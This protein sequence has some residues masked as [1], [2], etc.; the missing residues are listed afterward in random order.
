MSEVL[1]SSRTIKREAPELIIDWED[2]RDREP[3]GPGADE[4]RRITAA[5]DRAGAEGQVGALRIVVHGFRREQVIDR[6]ASDV[7]VG[8][9]GR[10]EFDDHLPLAVIIAEAMNENASG[11]RLTVVPP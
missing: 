10:A 8:V 4:A 1:T 5:G 2:H 9:I 7:A 11:H 3:T 6:I